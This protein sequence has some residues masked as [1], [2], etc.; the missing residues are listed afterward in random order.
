[1]KWFGYLLLLCC[2]LCACSGSTNNVVSDAAKETI[3]TIVANKPTCKDVGLACNKQ[4]DAITASYE[5]QK[6]I[7]TQEKI[8]WKYSFFGLLLVIGL[9][10][11]KRII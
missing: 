2:I 8:R 6:K 3:N 11:V 1:M 4:I 7:I 5:D 9:W 10:I